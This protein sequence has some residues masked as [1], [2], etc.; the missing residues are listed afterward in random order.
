MLRGIVTRAMAGR[1]ATAPGRGPRP[2]PATGR[3]GA[4]SANREIERGA[5]SLVRGLGRK[6]RGL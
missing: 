6:R 1:R 5:R 2:G 4:G 3:A